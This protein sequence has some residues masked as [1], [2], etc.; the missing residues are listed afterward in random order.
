MSQLNLESLKS[1]GAFVGRPVEKTV[2]WKSADGEELTAQVFVRP[3]SY[4]TAVS[5]IAQYSSKGD[6]IAGRIAACICDKDGK[7]IFTPEDIT[8]DAD[9]ERGAMCHEL[10]TALLT[11]IGETAIRGKQKS[12]RPKKKSGTS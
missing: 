5:D 8:G 9:P 3:L 11:V 6:V 2:T 4:Q 12:R 1:M 7:P 10:T